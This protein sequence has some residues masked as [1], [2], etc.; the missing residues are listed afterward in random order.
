MPCM[1]RCYK[2]QEK[3]RSPWMGVIT[4]ALTNNWGAPD[5]LVDCRVFRPPP[6]WHW[7]RSHT[8]HSVTICNM[9]IAKRDVFERLWQTTLQQIAEKAG[10]LTPVNL[11]SFCRARTLSAR[12]ADACTDRI[13]S[14]LEIC[15]VVADHLNAP[16]PAVMQGIPP[17]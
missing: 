11:V 2:L 7:T 5:V 17:M 13:C 1:R 3:L 9:M 4:A 14:R 16:F 8:G 6:R 15:V 12:Q 10:G